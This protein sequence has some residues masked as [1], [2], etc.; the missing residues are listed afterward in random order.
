LL[1]VEVTGGGGG[2]GR[3]RTAAA[4]AAAGG[5]GG[6]VAHCE[7]VDTWQMMSAELKSWREALCQGLRRDEEG[8]VVLVSSLVAENKEQW[9]KNTQSIYQQN[10]NKIGFPNL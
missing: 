3:D 10:T 5:G 7:G 4:A 2:G 6:G 8:V 9:R 1:W